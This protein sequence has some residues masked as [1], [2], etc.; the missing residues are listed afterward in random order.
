MPGRRSDTARS[1]RKDDD[2]VPVEPARV[3]VE[4]YLP[5]EQIILTAIGI[6]KHMAR[7]IYKV[8]DPTEIFEGST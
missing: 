4:V 1:G 5:P 3:D 6:C 7:Y 2:S 8:T